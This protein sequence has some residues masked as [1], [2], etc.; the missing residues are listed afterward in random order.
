MKSARWQF[1]APKGLRTVLVKSCPQLRGY[2]RVLHEEDF[3]RLYLKEKLRDKDVL[4][5]CRCS[6]NLLVCSRRFYR[7]KYGKQLH[8]LRCQHYSE[9]MMSNSRGRKDRPAVLLSYS[10]LKKALWSG[11]AYEK[12]AANLGVSVFTL[13]RNVEYHGLQKEA[14]RVRQRW[15]EQRLPRAV[16]DLALLRQ[17]ELLSPGLRA[18]L[19]HYYAKPA[20]YFHHLYRAFVTLQQCLWAVQKQAKAHSYFVAKKRVPKDH[21]A[22]NCNRAEMLLSEALLSLKISHQRLVPLLGVNVDFLLPKKRVVVEVN[23]SIHNAPVVKRR[24]KRKE[25]A[26]RA[27]GYRLLVL[28]SAEVIAKPTA[29]AK[30][31]RSFLGAGSKK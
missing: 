19:E 9:S 21:V 8:A 28:D 31:V 14:Q 2:S 23:G 6:I 24:D 17:L 13:T 16:Q 29:A 22:W 10:R 4:K 20:A 12:I 15:Q 1:K 18:S 3:V 27:A 7:K 11:H 26:I 30:K 25:R 5:R